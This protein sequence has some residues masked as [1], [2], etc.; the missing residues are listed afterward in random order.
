MTTQSKPDNAARQAAH[1]PSPGNSWYLIK[2][3]LYYRPNG[4]GYTN[5]QSEAGVFSEAYAE[6]HVRS[7]AG[8]K[9][10]S[11]RVKMI[12]VPS[13]SGSRSNETDLRIKYEALN[14]THAALLEALRL[15]I[16]YHSRPFAG[17]SLADF[18]DAGYRGT[19]N[20]SDMEEW[21]EERK[22]AA[23]SQAEGSR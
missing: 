2:R 22:R 7:T 14:L 23:L 12:R 18:E 1:A 16:L 4:A 10:P 6:D 9:D 8:E 11:L 17:N 19:A 5:V 15:D 20:K 13:W 3:G 21:L